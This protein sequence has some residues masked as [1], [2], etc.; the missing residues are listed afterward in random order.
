MISASPV[1]V[2]SSVFFTLALLTISVLVLLLLR[3]FLTLR[4][5]PAY[6]SIPV[7]LALALP[8]SV[9]LLVPIDLASSSRDG[10]GPTAIWLPD[11]LILVSWRIAYW[12]IF[13]LT[14]AILPLLGE[15]IDSGYRDPKGRIQ[16]SIRSNARYQLIVLCCAT[17]GLIYISIQN[18]FEF[19]SIKTLVMALAYVWGLVLAIYLMGHG[20][21]SIPRTLFRNS[22]V[23]GRLRRI[24]AHAPK[25]H[26]RLMDAINDLESLE[27][28]VAQLQRRKTGTARDFQEWIDELAETSNPPELRSGLL[29]HADGPGT[30]PAVITERYLADLTRRLQRARHQKARFVDEWDRLVLSAADMQAIINASASKKLE[31]IHSPHRSSWLPSLNFLSPY[32]RY[33]LYVHVIP[34]VRLALGAVFSAASVCVVWSELVKSLAPRL[35]VVTLSIVSYHKEP[36]PVDFGRQLIASAWLL[37][38]C[39]AALVGVNDAKVWGNRALVRRNTYGESACWYAGLVAR[40]T[41]PIAYNFLTFLPATVRQNTTFYKFLG[42]FID[43]TPL[44]KGFDYFFPVFILVPIGATLFNLYGRVQNICSWGLLE[45][46]DDDLENNPGGYGLGGWRE[47]RDL[48]DR[49]LNGLGSLG[50]SPR[51]GRSPR[52]SSRIDDDA[53]AFSSSRTALLES[54]RTPRA[55]RGT[56]ATT[57]LMEDEDED[58]F[59]QSFAHRVKN[60]FETASKPQWLQGDSFRLP[61]WMGS[62]SNEGDSGLAR[63][64]GGRPAPG[65]VRLHFYMRYPT[66][67]D[68]YHNHVTT[69]LPPSLYTLHH[70]L[71]ATL[72]S[73]KDSTPLRLLTPWPE[74]LAD[75]PDSAYTTPVAYTLIVC[76]IVILV[77]SWRTPFAN[78]WRRGYTNVDNTPQ[79]TDNDYSYITQDDIVNPPANTYRN[80]YAGAEDTEPDTL[81]LKHRKEKYDLHFPAY[82]I[83]DGALSVGQLR[84]RAAEATRTPDPKR[85]KLLYKGKLLDN[86]SLPCRSEGLKQQSE[87]L[88]VVSG[89]E[90]GESSPSEL[91]EAEADRNAES[92]RQEGSGRKKPKNKKR[93]GKNKK[94]SGKQGD[95]SNSLPPPAEEPPRPSNG[96]GMPPP[97]PNL[98]SFNNP[99]DQVNAL[100]SYLQRELVPLC[101]EYITNTPADAKSREFE[102]KKLTETI[103]AQVLLNADNINPDGVQEIRDARRAL[104]KSAQ[105]ALN[106]LDQVSRT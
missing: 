1:P 38:M 70:Q 97:A 22:N 61:R 89:V 93:N 98:K 29:E 68:E 23:S 40:L 65:G 56:P 46:E 88:C 58:N 57:P 64:F 101:E 69:N 76:T 59:F 35:S 44:G 28:Q 20:L 74:L 42:R 21:V 41:V 3:R 86:D 10:G 54:S 6:L 30:I 100:S 82:A 39:S 47:G 8:A 103:L 75:H 36:A 12:L 66:K 16:Y 62:E 50:L 105:N 18:G 32:M 71:V 91:S 106:S 24:Q 48:I 53:P 2:G 49:E 104:V 37:Y 79:V 9:V 80:Q 63:W 34:N 84:Q 81:I 73:A 43:L 72:S 67:H 11:R 85:I 95:G 15:Y 78:L 5:T 33:H 55:S 4:A 19:T 102:Y 27:S 87:V 17:V 92:A 31:F 52:P 83:N 7:F 14:W 96:A 77:M 51:G 60:T 45:E 25:L 26:D 13:V 90:P 94:K 99:I